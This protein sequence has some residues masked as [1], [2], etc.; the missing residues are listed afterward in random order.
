MTD[1]RTALPAGNR[2]LCRADEVVRRSR[3]RRAAAPLLDD[4][5]IAGLGHRARAEI[6]ADEDG[7]AIDPVH[8]AL[9][10]GQ[11]EAFWQAYLAL[12]RRIDLLLALPLA[13]L[14]ELSLAERLRAIGKTADEEAAL[15]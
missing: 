13:S 8:L 3:Q 7:V 5:G 9:G 14:D 2:R 1:H 4:A 6:G 11:R 12:K 10:D 15:G